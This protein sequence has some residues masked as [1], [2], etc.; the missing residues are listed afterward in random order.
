MLTSRQT[1]LVAGAFHVCDDALKLG[2]L[3]D[4]NG[5]S[6]YIVEERGRR[7]GNGGAISE[8]DVAVPSVRIFQ[9]QVSI[10]LWRLSARASG[11]GGS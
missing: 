6:S 4:L 10:L 1:G 3:S 11:Q 9:W 8:K 5:A 2:R 7:G